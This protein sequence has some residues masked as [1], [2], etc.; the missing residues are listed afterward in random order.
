MKNDLSSTDHIELQVLFFGTET[1][2]G[3]FS[4]PH[5]QNKTNELKIKEK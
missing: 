4:L 1:E 2:K 3:K 5:I